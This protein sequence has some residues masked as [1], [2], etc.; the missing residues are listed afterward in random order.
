MNYWDFV[1]EFFTSEAGQW[2]SMCLFLS[3]M[4]ILSIKGYH[5]I[6]DHI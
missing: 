2:F 1:K 6:R 5:W 3:I 4:L